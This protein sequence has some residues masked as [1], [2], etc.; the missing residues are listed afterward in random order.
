MRDEP[1]M[2]T[3]VREAALLDHCGILADEIDVDALADDGGV[4]YL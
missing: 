3:S 1:L 4:W 2:I